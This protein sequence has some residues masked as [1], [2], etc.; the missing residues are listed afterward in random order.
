MA[1][2]LFAG[3][4]TDSITVVFGSLSEDT[5]YIDGTYSDAGINVAY[6][7]MKIQC[8][9]PAAAPLLT[10]YSVPAGSA[11]YFH[12]YVGMNFNGAGYSG[13]CLTFFD[14]AGYPWVKLQYT[15]QFQYNSGTG[16]APVWTN[17]GS[18]TYG[19][20]GIN[21][22][23]VAMDIQIKIDSGGNHT[24]FM[25][26]N[27][28]QAVATAEFVQ[29]LMTNLSYAEIQHDPQ[30][31]ECVWS[32]I[33]MT[34]NISTVG[35]HV[36]TAR[37]TGAG[38]HSDWSGTYTDVNEVATNNTTYNQALTAG[39]LQS[40]PMG[41]IT[42]PAGC[43]IQG[44]FNWMIAKNDGTSPNNIA[45]LIRT[46]A[47]VDHASADLNGLGI[48]FAGLGAMYPV[49]PDT[50]AAWTQTD[51]NAPVQLGFVSEV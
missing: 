10:D 11:L 44:V 13:D 47:A 17:F 22:S 36:A 46:A 51:W 39:L 9:D 12:S 29:P 49:N 33:M 15:G 14:S 6:G 50:S 5:S 43:R 3:S 40:Y 41:N 7:A 34:E 31:T 21:R 18:N 19:M 30:N 23:P 16:A 35:G 4:R 28:I 2:L 32:Q 1:K 20:P 24:L 27:S 38:A 8:Y 42:V 45:S 25:A 48:A 26:V 37:A